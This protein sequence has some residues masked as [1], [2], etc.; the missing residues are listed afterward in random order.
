MKWKYINLSLS[1]IDYYKVI[2]KGPYSEY[3]DVRTESED[4]YEMV[5][6]LFRYSELGQEYINRIRAVMRR[7]NLVKYDKY[8]IDP[9]YINE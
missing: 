7:S 6:Y 8:R 4:P 5:N 3:R 9:K 2:A 1:I